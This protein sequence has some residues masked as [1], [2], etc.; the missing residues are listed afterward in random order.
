MEKWLQFFKERTP[1]LSY[2]LI[3]LGP[4]SSGHVLGGEVKAHSPLISFIGFFLFFIVLRMMD[5]Y[6]DY[7]KDILAHPTR[8]LPRGL[9]PLPKFN[10]AIGLVTQINFI[11]KFF[12][13]DFF[14]VSGGEHLDQL[15]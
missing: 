7:E 1:V 6:K 10:K 13:I 9:I 2:L 8:P 15:S 12:G 3:T 5:E 4:V 11:Q 14:S